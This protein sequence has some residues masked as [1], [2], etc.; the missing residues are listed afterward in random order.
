[1]SSHLSRERWRKCGILTRRQRIERAPGFGRLEWNKLKRAT[2]PEEELENKVGA[3]NFAL[4]VYAPRKRNMR[5]VTNS[6]LCD[7]LWL[8]PG[9]TFQSASV[10]SILI[11]ASHISGVD[12][13]TSVEFI[14]LDEKFTMLETNKP[15]NTE[16]FDSETLDEVIADLSN[17]VE[18]TLE[19]SPAKDDVINDEYEWWEKLKI[20]ISAAILTTDNVEDHGD[21]FD[22]C[23]AKIKSRR[24]VSEAD[25]TLRKR[26]VTRRRKMLLL[27][28]A[29]FE[30]C[31]REIFSPYDNNAENGVQGK[32]S[33]PRLN[34]IK[35]IFERSMR[36]CPRDCEG[37][38]PFAVAS[39]ASASIFPSSFS[40]K[41]S[42]SVPST[43]FEHTL[44]R[45]VIDRLLR[46]NPAAARLP[47][48]EDG[49][50]PLHLS[51]KCG[52]SWNDGIGSILK[53]YPN[54]L[55]VPDSNGWLPIHV[56][57]SSRKASPSVI[58]KL[59]KKYPEAAKVR[60]N[61]GR[62]PLHLA[63]KSC[64][65]WN[66]GVEEIYA[67]YPE[68]LMEPDSNGRLP[69]HHRV[70]ATNTSQTI[71]RNDDVLLN[72]NPLK[73][74]TTLIKALLQN[75]SK[76]QAV[77]YEDKTTLAQ[78]NMCGAP[79]TLMPGLIF[80]LGC[81][82]LPSASQMQNN[83]DTRFRDSQHGA[84]ALRKNFIF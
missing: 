43:Q 5:D 25:S 4:K 74:T 33:K 39:A 31:P 60:D 26:H 18:C 34:Y 69:A 44:S 55:A 82:N 20:L 72:Q 21:I 13:S 23:T 1:M 17:T 84:D 32:F 76:S 22:K 77:R 24:V 40:S 46:L 3:D 8:G 30:L 48:R 71:N 37:L 68:A 63:E 64:K 28:A 41:K 67:A 14:L 70:C 11:W 79:T 2:S 57:A 12:L 80:I 75:L 49:S 19:V 38:T 65:A 58:R 53:A 54:A 47:C 78:S 73:Y 62:L 6:R 36:L 27:Y 52:K 29:Y 59:L 50:L 51:V 7:M 56:A 83:F 9:V 16:I 61:E 66:S 10:S 15:E 42:H 35:K 45:K 81:P